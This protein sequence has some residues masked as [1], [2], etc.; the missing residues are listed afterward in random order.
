MSEPDPIFIGPSGV[1]VQATGDL[2][3]WRVVG[4]D[5]QSITLNI[6]ELAQL[7]QFTIAEYGLGMGYHADVALTSAT[8]EE[9]RAR[10]SPAFA[11]DL[12]RTVQAALDRMFGGPRPT[13]RRRAEP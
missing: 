10:L 2:T 4:K 12:E 7:A 13:P 1:T 11:D 8:L 3:A 9:Y 5:G 6:L